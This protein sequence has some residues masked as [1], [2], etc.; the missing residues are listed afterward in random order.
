MV[1]NSPGNLDVVDVQTLG[2]LPRTCREIVVCLKRHGELSAEELAEQLH[3]T[4]S[5]IRQALAPLRTD[6]LVSYRETGSGRG[7]RRHVYALTEEGDDLFPGLSR[8]LVRRLVHFLRD[9]APEIVDEFIADIIQIG[10]RRALEVVNLP[11]QRERLDAVAR[12]YESIRFLVEVEEEDGRQEFVVH[13][14]PLAALAHDFPSSVCARE[15]EVLSNLVRA[16]V[17]RPE[18]QIDGAPVCRYRIGKGR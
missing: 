14:C 12:F 10:E 2:S 17:E 4:V 7:R 1:T 6:G 9:R 11:T 15:A 3:L 8:P 13:H 16:D 5:T 18:W